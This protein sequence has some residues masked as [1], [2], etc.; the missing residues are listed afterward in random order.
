MNMSIPALTATEQ[1]ALLQPATCPCA[2]QSVTTK[3]PKFIRSFNMSVTSPL[4][5]A[6]FTPCQLEKLVITVATPFSI[7]GIGRAVDQA[8]FE[9]GYGRVALI[10]AVDGGAVGEKMLGARGDMRSGKDGRGR[11]RPLQPADHA[12]DIGRDER[13][14]RRISFIG[15]SPAVILRDRKSTR[16]NSSH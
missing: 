11:R 16:L 6:I 2:F 1:L 10:L 5:P 12:S 3:P 9:F 8:Q 15:A 4:C 14:V 7:A 13:G